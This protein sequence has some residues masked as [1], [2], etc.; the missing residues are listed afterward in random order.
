M[1]LDEFYK[2]MEG[3][4]ERGQ[5][6][7]G[8]V[9]KYKSGIDRLAEYLPHDDE[10]TLEEIQDY[11]LA[12]ASDDGAKGSTLNVDKCAIRKYLSFQGR[13]ETYRELRLWFS[14]NFRASSGEAKDALTREEMDAVRRAADE[15]PRDA[16]M[17]AIFTRT[18][19]RVGELIRLDVS[20]LEFDPDD[21]PDGIEGYITISRQKRREEVRDRRPLH[22]EDV[23]RIQA[24]LD[25]R[26]DYGAEAAAKTDALF[27][28]R[29]LTSMDSS[30]L[31]SGI[32]ADE[33]GGTY[34][35][36]DT[37]VGGWVKSLAERCDHEDVTRD[38]MHT[39]LFRHTVGT[40]L[41]QQDYTAVQIGEYLGKASPAER[42]VS[43]NTEKTDDMAD[44][45]L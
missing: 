37:A 42:Y 12:R 9:R 23:D 20:D 36:T 24:Y 10:P 2:F 21:A 38:R 22:G 6:A 18:G 4:V 43:V 16:A 29:S 15:D 25:V 33:R 17:V 39:H 5:L 27:F 19:L 45:V 28:T 31:P 7:K 8:T 32:E 41:G 11:I 30:H 44:A 13:A 1:D 40:W 35:P 34:R 14:D 26:A 3:Q